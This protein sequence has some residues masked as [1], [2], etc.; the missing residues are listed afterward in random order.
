[1]DVKP[2]LKRI[3]TFGLTAG[4]IFVC[5]SLLVFGAS[6]YALTKKPD[7]PDEAVL[8]LNLDRPVVEQPALPAVTG[9]TKYVIGQNP[10]LSANELA[11]IIRT[12]G[13]DPRIKR[14]VLDMDGMSLSGPGPTETLLWAVR[15]AKSTGT[16]IIAYASNYSPL[17]YLLASQADQ[18][19][20]NDMG[21]VDWNGLSYNALFFGEALEKLGVKVFTAQA[22]K[23]KSA[24]EPYIRAGFSDEARTS[25]T[26]TL[27]T[28]WARF[29]EYAAAGRQMPSDKLAQIAEQGLL[30]TEDPAMSALHLGLVDDLV[31]PAVLSDL[32]TTAEDNGS[33]ETITLDTWNAFIGKPS[34]E[35]KDV[36]LVDGARRGGRISII[37]L[38]GQIRMGRNAPG[39]IGA[40]STVGLLRAAGYHPETSGIILRIDSPGGDAQA[41]EIIRSTIMD[42]KARGIP[43]VVSMG[44]VTASGGYWITSAADYVFADQ[45]TTTGSL[46][47]FALLPSASEALARYGVQTDTIQVAGGSSQISIASPVS[48]RVLEQL[49]NRISGVYDR[50]LTTVSEGRSLSLEATKAAAAGRVWSAEAAKDLSLI[51]KIGSLETAVQYLTRQVQTARSCAVHI[52][53]PVNTADIIRQLSQP[54]LPIEVL[55]LK[56]AGSVRAACLNCLMWDQGRFDDL[57]SPPVLQSAAL[58]ALP[59][60]ETFDP[61]S[62]YK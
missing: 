42:I 24:I 61:D 40:H 29:V 36:S 19:L 38:A 34:C 21:S 28:L 52:R 13:E 33:Y 48:P 6:Y 11:R 16:E 22:G 9:V 41:S 27:E 3:I 50:F 25:M 7:I 60:F 51:D 31:T 1:M 56:E 45:L 2:A 53:L 62:I 44:S 20:M 35:T 17:S 47:A 37:T 55:E 5:M 23:Y 46:G 39:I 32:A 12:A 49:Q 10:E 59:I 43:V 26:Q 30:T 54:S 8:Y 18:V 14:I 58:N 57:L 4:G 15:D